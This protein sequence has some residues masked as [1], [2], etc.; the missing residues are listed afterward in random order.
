MADVADLQVTVNDAGVVER[1]VERLD[2]RSTY[3][4]DNRQGELK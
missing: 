1:A 3:R 4:N 2:G